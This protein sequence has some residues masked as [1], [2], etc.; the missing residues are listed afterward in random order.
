[1]TGP[2]IVFRPLREWPGKL[3]TDAQ[4]RSHYHFRATWTSTQNLIEYEA[5]RLGAREIVIQ[6][7]IGDTEIRRDG[8]PYARAE[9]RHPGVTIVLP[10]TTDQGRLSFSTDTY[11]TWRANVRAF[12]S[13]R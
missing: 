12:R 4:R 5:E 3:H 8:W 10:E 2:S 7:A 6:I 11:T 9:P 13:S 1:M